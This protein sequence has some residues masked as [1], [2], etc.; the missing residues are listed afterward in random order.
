MD[1]IEAHNRLDSEFEFF[2][3]HAAL[4]VKDKR[5]ELVAFRPNLAQRYAHDK[6]EE[7]LRTRGWVR[8]LILKGRQQ[9]LSTYI[10]ARFFWKVVRRAGLS[11]FILSHEGSTTDKLFAMVRR[12]YDNMRAAF[13]PALGKD[14]PRAMTFPGLGSDYAA[15][16]AGNEQVGRGGTAQLFHGS[17]AAYWE[18]AYAIQDGALKSI[19]LLPGTEVILESTANGPIGLFYQKCLQALSGLGDYILIFIPW[20]W[21]EEYEREPEPG[22]VLTEEEE[23]YARDN[24]FKKPFPYHHDT[25]SP[26]QALRKL[27]WRRAEIVDLST[28]A[29]PESGHAKFRSIYPS[30]PVEAFLSTA[31]GIIRPSAI[32]AARA[33]WWKGERSEF[34][35]RILG[36]DPAGDGKKADRTILYL[37]QGRRTEWVVK[38]PKMNSMELAG[39]VAKLI[40]EE[41]LDMVFVDRGYGQGTIDRLHELG[42]RSKVIGV[43]F[44]ETPSD[45][46]YLNKRSEIII[47]YAEHINSTDEPAQLPDGKEEPFGHGVKCSGDEIHADLAAMPLDKETSTGVKYIV[48]KE[49][50]TKLLGRS[51]DIFDAGALT[52]SYPVR[53]AAVEEAQ[54]WRKA[55]GARKASAGP[56]SSM[57]RRRSRSE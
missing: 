40:A 16:T 19:A 51:P 47:K 37:R 13:R 39:I 5:G 32:V 52:F 38:Y 28:G 42:F 31:V 3:E 11:A 17:E 34:A 8:A 6:L 44:S 29:N 15:G 36:V 24:F 41:D 30:N 33:A 50:I 49:Q 10:Q 7:Q 45:P 21:Q 9:G 43:H 54:R 53:R 1:A 48:P 12:F 35:A 25:I 22:F 20:F 46:V 55:G 4:K 56:L 26:Q 23:Q 2:A 18:H 14:N 57:N 27:A